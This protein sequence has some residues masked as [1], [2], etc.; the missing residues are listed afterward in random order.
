MSF[1]LLSYLSSKILITFSSFNEQT[2]YNV[3]KFF[4]LKLSER[5][6]ILENVK[7]IIDSNRYIEKQKIILDFMSVMGYVL[8]MFHYIQML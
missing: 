8:K 5:N 6:K 2:D 7:V 4:G 1:S 3:I